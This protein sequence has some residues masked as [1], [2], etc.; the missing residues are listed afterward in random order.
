M[1]VRMGVGWGGGVGARGGVFASHLPIRK[2][3]TEGERERG[4]ES[5]TMPS[6]AS[7]GHGTEHEQARAP[8]GAPNDRTQ[9]TPCGNACNILQPFRE[10]LQRTLGQVWQQINSRSERPHE[11]PAD[12]GAFGFGFGV[13]L[14]GSRIAQQV[15]GWIE[16]QTARRARHLRVLLGRFVM[17]G[18]N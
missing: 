15:D 3:K 11:A 6:Q 17:G 4:R 8:K 7:K 2:K 18:I 12:E 9:A 10:A 13:L 14:D 16:I 1:T 5:R